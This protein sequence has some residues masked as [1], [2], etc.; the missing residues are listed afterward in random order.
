M[1]T[2][3]IAKNDKDWDFILDKR[4]SDFYKP[5]RYFLNFSNLML[6]AHRN[7]LSIYNM[8]ADEKY[9]D[10]VDTMMFEEGDIRY[11]YFQQALRIKTA[12]TPKT[13]KALQDKKKSKD[14][15]KQAGK[16][17]P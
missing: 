12:Q 1:S 15:A 14:K 6:I 8:S 10:F 17:Q 9:D 16:K 2:A 4:V 11:M 5:Y 13:T 3:K 7:M